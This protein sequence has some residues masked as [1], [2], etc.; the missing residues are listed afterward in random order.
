MDRK[1]LKSKDRKKASRIGGLM[2][3]QLAE[4]MLLSGEMNIDGMNEQEIR[5]EVVKKIELVLAGKVNFDIVIDY[6]EFLLKKARA[7][8]KTGHLDLSALFY[9]TYFEHTLNNFI[10][11]LIVKHKLD[12]ETKKAILRDSKIRDKCTWILKVLCGRGIAKDHLNTINNISEMRNAFIHYKWISP[13]DNDRKK[14]ESHLNKAESVVRYL[15][16]YEDRYIFQKNK[17]RIKKTLSRRK[18][19]PK[20]QKQ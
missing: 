4:Q 19:K 9:A 8:Y 2:V 10:T 16:G 13:N 14:Y 15:K 18:S 5:R 6:T 7:E 17:S 3:Q 1:P 11:K 12:A 20:A